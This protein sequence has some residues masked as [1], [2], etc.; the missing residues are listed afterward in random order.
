[1]K[2]NIEV[3]DEQAQEALNAMLGWGEAQ[4]GE[5]KE[6]EVIEK[7]KEEEIT[8]TEEP[9]ETQ[10]EESGDDAWTPKKKGNTEKRFQKILRQKNEAL[11]K[12]KEY[13]EKLDQLES[14]DYDENEYASDRDADR[15]VVRT[16]AEKTYSERRAD[17]L[18]I[19]MKESFFEET[20]GADKYREGILEIMTQN[21][22]LEIDQAHKLYLATN[23]PEQLVD[24]YQVRKKNNNG[25]IGT[26]SGS[27]WAKQKPNLK[28]IS[29][30]SKKDL[31]NVSTD[32]MEKF[33]GEAS[34][35]WTILV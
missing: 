21:P 4:A 19:D 29:K 22:S 16:E 23:H 10:S 18:D 3:T 7:E 5:V 6:E 24:K 25:M 11:A 34:A 30:M 20:P 33:L 2:N 15:A 35:Q 31:D 17:E 14:G 12:A 13:K 27:Q 28:N 1:M 26:W 9:E 8:E 32:D